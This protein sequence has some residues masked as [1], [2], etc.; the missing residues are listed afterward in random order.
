MKIQKEKQ[1]SKLVKVLKT[2]L[3][4]TGMSK[5]VVGVKTTTPNMERMRMFSGT[6]KID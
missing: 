2:L 3:H 1:V 6:T 5:C 4:K